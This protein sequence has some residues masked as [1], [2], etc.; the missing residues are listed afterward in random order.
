MTAKTV[1]YTAEMVTRMTEA[2]VASPTAETV[3]TLATE[4]GKT[5]KSIVAKLAQL[6][7]YRKAEKAAGEKAGVSKAEMALAIAPGDEALQNDLVKLTK[8][9]LVKI[10]AAFE[11][12]AAE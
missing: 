5:G 6:G 10:A 4:F 9:S 11:A 7:I 3:A 8:A 2:Y 1:A 12:K